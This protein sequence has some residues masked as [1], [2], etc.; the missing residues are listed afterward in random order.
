MLNASIAALAVHAHRPQGVVL[1]TV[2]TIKPPANIGTLEAACLLD[3]TAALAVWL[4]LKSSGN[5]FDVGCT[6]GQR[7]RALAVMLH[8][9]KRCVYAVDW[10]GEHRI[11]P[12]QRRRYMPREVGGAG[13]QLNNFTVIDA[14]P[15]GL[16]WNNFQPIGFVMLDYDY[17][18]EGLR[19]VTKP[20][21]EAVPLMATPN[22]VIAW[23]GYREPKPEEPNEVRMYVQSLDL[24]DSFHVQGSQVAFKVFNPTT[25]FREELRRLA[26]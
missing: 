25:Q 11:S 17:S 13:C 21:L 10:S 19:R 24:A 14:D 8:R 16:P 26:I 3:R 23:S 1:Q 6:T 4:A 12:K 2:R 15:A 20:A 18:L 7:A 9:F 22:A 5:A